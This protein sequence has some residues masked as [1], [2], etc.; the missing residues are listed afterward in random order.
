MTSDRAH[1]LELLA[2]SL[3]SEALA[4]VAL[5]LFERAFVCPRCGERTDWQPRRMAPTIPD[6]DSVTARRA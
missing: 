6:P 5:Q 1:L 3:K 4:E 2:R